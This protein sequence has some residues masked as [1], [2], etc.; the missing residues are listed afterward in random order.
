[1]RKITAAFGVNPLPNLPG[2]HFG[3]F[4]GVPCAINAS[5]KAARVSPIKFIGP[6]GSLRGRV[7]TSWVIGALTDI[8]YNFPTVSRPA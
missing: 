1:L 4:I 2:A 5:R 3:L 6:S 7:N 8:S